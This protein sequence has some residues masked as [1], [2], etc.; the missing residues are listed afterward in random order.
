MVQ[1]SVE[2][3]EG[4]WIPVAEQEISVDIMHD[5]CTIEGELPE[6]ILLGETFEFDDYKDGLKLMKR[7]TENGWEEIEISDLEFYWNSDDPDAWEEDA[8]T[9]KLLRKTTGEIRGTIQASYEETDG[10]EQRSSDVYREVVFGA[11]DYY[12]YFK[13]MRSGEYAT[14]IFEDEQYELTLDIENLADKNVKIQW[15][16]GYCVEEGEKTK[17]T[18]VSQKDFGSFWSEYEEN[19][20]ILLI[21]GK[22]LKEAYESLHNKFGDNSW[23][24]VNAAIVSDNEYEMPIDTI[25]VSIFTRDNVL[26]YGYP[27]W[28]VQMLPGEEFPIEK[29]FDC[30]EENKNYP[31]GHVSTLTV[32]NVTVEGEDA[33]V[34]VEKKDDH[35]IITA[36]SL[37]DANVI[38]SY[39]DIDGTLQEHTIEFYVTGEIYAMAADDENGASWILNG[40]EM[41][42]SVKVYRQ[43]LDENGSVKI[44][45]VSE[46]AYTL[47][48][49]DDEDSIYDTNILDEVSVEG[50][51]LVVRAN[52]G[53]N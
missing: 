16:V 37:G 13:D 1:A 47:N 46:N 10:E 41:T 28:S 43:E 24:D 39:T 9:G 52:L 29:S 17:Y 7:S 12:T 42:I 53:S 32:K 6:N 51:S 19:Q 36:N 48:V 20:Y 35:W 15:E 45:E 8:S 18:P 4:N 40:E 26:D 38:L 5:F 50:S 31:F 21:D 22:A 33:P 30:Y 2:D 25:G 11:L 23:F 27:A 14:E 49:L 44:T 3:E 34:T